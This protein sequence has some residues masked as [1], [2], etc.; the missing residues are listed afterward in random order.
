MVQKVSEK[1][2]NVCRTQK[3]EKRYITNKTDNLLDKMRHI[4]SPLLIQF[5]SLC[6]CN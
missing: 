2:E 1:T 3:N 5:L 4:N 6:G